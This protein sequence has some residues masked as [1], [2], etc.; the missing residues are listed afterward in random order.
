MGKDKDAP[1][2]A[3]KRASDNATEWMQEE[4]DAL[5]MRRREAGRPDTSSEPTVGLAL[6]GGGIRSATFCLG[7]VRG[8]A[9]NGLLPRID[10]LSTVSGGGYTGAVLGRLAL[11]L[12]IDRAQ[13]QLKCS[14]SITLMW[15][16]RY[17]RYLA[18]KGA[19]DYG[20]ATATYL[21][22][23]AAIHLEL[24]LLAMLVAVLIVV[25]HVA[26]LSW[27][28][29]QPEA[30]RA[31]QTAWWPLAAAVW[32][33]MAPGAMAMYWTLRDDTAM[34]SHPDSRAVRPVD[35]LL[36]GV[37]IGALTYLAFVPA[38]ALGAL[39]RWT[40]LP[41]VTEG[42]RRPLGAPD[43]RL[44]ATLLLG[45]LLWH[46]LSL[47]IR[48]A[49]R[50]TTSVGDRHAR[51]RQRLTHV[52]RR[53]NLVAVVMF[54]AGAL[55]LFTWTL[56]GWLENGIP[57]LVGGLGFGG[58]LVAVGR[59]FIEPLQK[60]SAP[61]DRRGP[62]SGQALLHLVG[63][64]IALALLVA[65]TTWVQWVVFGD[66]DPTSG[67]PAGGIAS[68]TFLLA[69]FPLLWFAVTAVNRETANNSSL[70]NFYRARL[71]RAYLGTGNTRRFGQDLNLA[72]SSACPEEI[73]DV[74]EVVAGDDVAL[75]DYRP[76]TRGGPIHL[77]NV[78]L[79]QTRSDRGH[80]YNA[81]RKGLRMTIS[82]RGLEVGPRVLLRSTTAALA[83][84]GRWI[85][86][87]GAAASPGAGSYTSRGWALMLFMV[88]AR[89]GY[90]FRPDPHPALVP[91]P[92][93]SMPQRFA[94]WLGTTKLGLL[95][96]EALA[97][98]P[99]PGQSRWYLS[100][101]GHFD[102][103]GVHALLRRELDFIVLADCGADPKFE[104]ADLENLIRKARIDYDA[105]IEFYT[106]DGARALFS[107][108]DS[109]LCVLSPEELS[110][111]YT[112]RGVLLA[113]ICYRSSEPGARKLGTL[114]VVK[115]NLHEALDADLLAYAR[116]HPLF[117]Q[118]P[119]SD[120]F[121]DEAQWESYHRLGQ[122]FGRA[123]T[124]CWLAQLP[125]WA[126]A[127]PR[128]DRPQP[129]RHAV[130]LHGPA[131][132]PR[133]GPHWRPEVKAAALG[134][135]LG[136]G[137]LGTL[138]VPVWQFAD[139]V[140]SK[141]EQQARIAQERFARLL[142]TNL[143]WIREG[144]QPTREELQAIDIGTEHRLAE[145]FEAVRMQPV[146]RLSAPAR[147][148]RRVQDACGLRPGTV[149]LRC[150]PAA[151]PA[152]ECLSVCDSQTLW[153]DYWPTARQLVSSGAIATVAPSP[154]DNRPASQLTAAK[155]TGASAQPPKQGGQQQEEKGP[156]LS[157]CAARNV[158]VYVQTYDEATRTLATQLPWRKHGIDMP[159]VENVIRTAEV[160]GLRPPYRW[161]QPTLVVHRYAEN[162]PC[163]NALL[164]WLQSQPSLQH[165]KEHW[166]IG[167]LPRSFQSNEDIIEVWL[168]TRPQSQ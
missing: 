35:M 156:D 61:T 25:P 76:E 55:D 6:S 88:G 149:D 46:A 87:S 2:L 154:T 102:N 44:V 8:L 151:M 32:L 36:V 34:A 165:F 128:V 135:T 167:A 141:N 67:A 63:L 92:P 64:V 83:T 22:A 42:W 3:S 24:G 137:A 4:L 143:P 162:A 108:P 39:G 10:Y 115:P 91:G 21:R 129:L 43:A 103:T 94:R 138:A 105:E 130:P 47:W 123:L 28:V 59:S 134:A 119:T 53:A 145:L 30:W 37:L 101:G 27:N 82:P 155:Q 38:E 9:H 164:T 159:G 121:F 124:P 31:W 152:S 117:P 84:L 142:E 125:G 85:A 14:D 78:C 131:D 70:H 17:G 146:D 72:A 45:G 49:R 81:D 112:A 86:V 66:L 127:A 13:E 29:V 80:V 107:L 132:P 166:R 19:R 113:R 161:P 33:L 7:L 111:N 18:P 56:R 158:V 139:H 104:L 54:V 157:T 100:D 77:I 110:S 58:L 93:P 97:R 79:N 69:I 126:A 41:P 20:V 26:Q 5:R 122:D 153:A 136:I 51:Q 23:A 50:S 147:L 118:Q 71:T 160:K 95:T 98:F 99:G 96:S 109:Q 75:A 65:W 133:A 52:L 150:P 89:L 114:L 90:W 1:D 16:R 68:R 106:R 163:A 48:L 73:S 144:R 74:T 60:L 148:V 15:L 62:F 120:Q 12:G 168:P 40:H 11:A 140:A 57:W 116:R